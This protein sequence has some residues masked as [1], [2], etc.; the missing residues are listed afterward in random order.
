MMID[1]MPAAL[2]W[3]KDS[4]VFDSVYDSYLDF[5]GGVLGRLM[6]YLQKQDRA[7]YD[8]LDAQIQ[9]AGDSAFIRVL[10]APETT[11]RLLAPHL[12]GTSEVADFMRTALRLEAL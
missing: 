9:R 4:A 3:K 10:T 11:R 1:R 12:F 8:G 2:T 5:L 6:A 7:S